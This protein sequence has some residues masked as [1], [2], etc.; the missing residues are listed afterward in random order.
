M[1]LNKINT[2]IIINIKIFIFFMLLSSPV[3]LFFAYQFIEKTIDEKVFFYKEWEETVDKSEKQQHLYIKNECEINYVF[4]KDEEVNEFINTLNNAGIRVCK[5]NNT[6]CM[7]KYICTIDKE[8]INKDHYAKEFTLIQQTREDALSKINENKLVIYGKYLSF[9]ALFSLF[10]L[11]LFIFN[12][13]A[14]K[15]N[16]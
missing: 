9:A 5:D 6:I 8:K 1:Y 2:K 14:A 3:A 15:K 11:L 4:V 7:K 12:P 16:P 10:I 13:F